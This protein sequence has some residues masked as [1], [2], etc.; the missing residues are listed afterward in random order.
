LGGWTSTQAGD[1]QLTFH[2]FE[3]AANDDCVDAQSIASGVHEFDT[4]CA[5]TDGLPHDDCQWNGQT[6]ND[7]W[8]EWTAPCTGELTVSTC[9]IADFDTDLVLYHTGGTC[10]PGDNDLIACNDDGDGCSGYTSELSAIVVGGESY[11]IRVGGYGSTDSGG[12]TVSVKCEPECVGDVDDSGTVDIEDLLMILGAYGGSDAAS[13]VNGDG[14]V[15]INDLLL[16]I[17]TWGP[18]N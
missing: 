5:S 10:P 6:Y 9:D 17:S 8:F 14:I 2:L 13:D 12:G 4:R 11:L 18:C 7:V 1:I 16:V 3:G 15:D